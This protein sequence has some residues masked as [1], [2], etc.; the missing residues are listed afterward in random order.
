M[1][2]LPEVE[3]IRQ[4]LKKHTLFKRLKRA[5][6]MTPKMVRGEVGQLQEVL[7]NNRFTDIDRVGKLLIFQ[8]ENSPLS[9]LLHLKMTGQLIYPVPGEL[10]AGGHPFPE[11]NV[12]LPN[13]Y[14]H[15]I[16]EFEDESSLYFND[17]R[18]FGYVQL[19]TPKE[20]VAVRAQYG[21]EPGM[22][23]FTWENFSALVS[24]RATKL[25][26]FLLSQQHIAG[27]GNIYAD[28]VAFY[29]GVRPD[30]TLN[31]LTIAEKKKLYTG[32]QEIIA[33]AVEHKGTTFRNYADHEG[34]RGGYAQFLQVYG[35][36]GQKCQRCGQSNITKVKL[37]GRGTHFCEVCQK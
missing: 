17:L 16:F 28:E 35:R 6:V 36:A 8:L 21:L 26:P 30:R 9:M 1:P 10:V 4:G 34:K 29:A 22:D 13:K 11:F 25:K 37:A 18:Q 31:S 2:E 27:L 20:L 12:D 7:A 19:V 5:L 14:T 23:D 32:I 3:T 24:G 15:L 33:S